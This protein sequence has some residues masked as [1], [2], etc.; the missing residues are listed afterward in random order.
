MAQRPLSPHVFIYRFA[1]TMATSIFH[2][3]TGVVMSCG[4]LLLA[5][6]LVSLASGP[7]SYAAF[8][9]F[10]GSWPVRVLLSLLLLCFCYHFANGIRHLFWDAGIGLLGAFAMLFPREKLMMIPIPIGIPAWLFVT[11]YGLAELVFGVTGTLSGIAHF[12]HLGGLFAGL[13][14]LWA[15]GVRSP[16]RRWS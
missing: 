13:L 10:A 3:A 11:L 7:Q 1:Y 5:G 16:P 6:F 12:A 8:L 14:L 9:V 15:W 2:R 4:L